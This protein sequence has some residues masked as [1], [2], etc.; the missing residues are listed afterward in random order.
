M[1]PGNAS[2]VDQKSGGEFKLQ[3]LNV[4]QCLGFRPQR[5]QN[6]AAG[7]ISV[8][9]QNAI[10]AMRAFAGEGKFGSVA[11]ELGA[12]LNQFIDPL[13][14][15]FDENLGS[16]DV[17]QSVAGVERVLKVES[18]FIFV[19]ERGG[20]SALGILRSGVGDFAFGED[21]DAAGWSQFDGG[22][23]PGDSRSNYQKICFGRHLLHHR[24]WYHA[25]CGGP[26]SY[27]GQR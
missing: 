15:F 3:D 9:V 7:R 26:L 25:K 27:D 1:N 2:V 17:A 21:N 22:P 14:T 5:A 8:S 4:G 16:F 23:Q 11:I 18:D 24:K 6:F 12:P 13:G 10:A 20:D 19:A